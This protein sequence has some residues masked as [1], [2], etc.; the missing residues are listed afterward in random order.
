MGRKCCDVCEIKVHRLSGAK[1]FTLVELM[2]ATLL[3]SVAL[4]G[5]ASLATVV[6]N[7]NNISKQITTSTALAQQKIEY[8]FNKGYG[9]GI[10]TT[11][12]Y[13]E[14]FGTISSVVNNPALFSGYRRVTTVVNGPAVNTRKLTVD[15]YRKNSTSPTSL[16]T[17]IAK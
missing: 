16:S 8:Y 4:L 1:G 12:T 10:Y 3:F 17:I 9:Y 14:P 2:I 13:T 6:I 5:I 7:G 11:A 15:V